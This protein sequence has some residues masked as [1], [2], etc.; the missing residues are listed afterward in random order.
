[1]CTLPRRG[2]PARWSA[3]AGPGRSGG[4]RPGFAPGTRAASPS[5]WNPTAP[6]HPNLRESQS[7]N[8]ETDNN[9]EID[10]TPPRPYL[11]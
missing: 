10:P 9:L 7:I 4:A 1:M 5:Q 11:E 6:Q 8:Q 2:P 3:K